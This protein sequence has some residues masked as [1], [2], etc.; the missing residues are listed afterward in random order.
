MTT[1]YKWEVWCVTD[2]KYETVWKESAPT[3][4]P[5]NAAHTI[6]NPRFTE[7]VST[8]M[9]KIIEE[10]KQA[11][12]GIYQFR[13][14][15]IDIPSGTPGNVTAIPMTWPR[16][17]TIMNGWFHSSNDN[18]GD[19]IDANVTATIGYIV[20]PAYATNTTFTVN[21]TVMENIYTGYTMH[22]TDFVNID[23]LGEVL[24]INASNNT[25]TTAKPVSRTYSPAS[26]TYVQITSRLIRDLYIPTSGHYTF[27]SKKVGGRALPTNQPLV[28][29][30]TNNDGNAKVYAYNMEY[31]Y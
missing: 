11:S 7:T 18:V 29:N 24:S 17:I 19:S 27:A 10:E 15:K 25:I 8:Q 1:L 26:P 5:S 30:Y 21:S 23:H 3:V 14:Y 6:Q 28:I 12:Q 9:T 31:L 2:A 13:G 20:A 16:A 22:L 4:C